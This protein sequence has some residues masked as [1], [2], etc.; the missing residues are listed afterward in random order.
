MECLL[1]IAFRDF[2]LI[3]SDMTNAHSI[4]VMKDDEDKL[5][6]IS[7]KLVMAISG[8]S[9]DTT[10]FAE[11]IA[12]NIQLYK[13]RNGYELSPNAAANFTRRNL[14]DYLRSRTPY[15]VNLLLAGY[16]DE[17]GPELYFVDYLA[18]MVKVPYAAHGYGGFFSLSIM[19]R[20]HKSDMSQEEAYE[21]MKKCVREIH[22]RLVVNL[23]NFKVQLIN[24]DG[25]QDLPPI[26]AKNLSIEEASVPLPEV[27]VI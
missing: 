22:K 26:T 4:M 27:R 3:A 19:D 21:L 18:S 13:M 8:E 25:I 16:N 20:H 12:K 15:F 10:Q 17:T 1:G 9:G 23:P 14:A 6:K 7:D 5:H 11:Y 24:K 2:V